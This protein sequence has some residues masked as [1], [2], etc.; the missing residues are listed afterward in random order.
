[1]SFYYNV[2]FSDQ[3]YI[4][5]MNYSKCALSHLFPAIELDLSDLKEVLSEESICGKNALS[6]TPE[7]SSQMIDSKHSDH[8]LLANIASTCTSARSGQ[9]EA[10]NCEV[11]E[12]YCHQ[13][14]VSML[15]YEKR[16]CIRFM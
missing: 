7:G 3:C 4:M 2:C 11:S 10:Y 9:L 16:E 12:T 8:V 15:L 14:S 13:L 1:M 5:D 6:I